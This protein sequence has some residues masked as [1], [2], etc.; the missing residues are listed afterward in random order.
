MA[1]ETATVGSPDPTATSTPVVSSYNEWDP[2]EEVIVG[3]AEGAVRSAYEPAVS[4]FIPPGDAAREF[5]GGE[6]FAEEI[7]RAQ[8]QLDGLA[9]LLESRGIVVRRP[10]PVDHD[11]EAVTPDF[12]CALGHAQTCPRDVL[13]VV[14]EEIIEAPM[15][16]RSRYFEYR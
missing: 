13:L 3:V 15:A 6:F 9:A 5:R 8:E 16:Q 4:P 12:E 11:F 14:G 7:A 2:L 10:D 1:G